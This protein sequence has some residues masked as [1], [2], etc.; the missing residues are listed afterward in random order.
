MKIGIAQTKPI[1]G[2]IEKNVQQHLKIIDRAIAHG[3][4]I[5][6]FPELSITGYEPELSKA[7]ATIPSDPRWSV[8]QEKADENQITI[9]L[10]L[11]MKKEDQSICI[12]MFIF[13]PAE[14]IQ[15]YSKEYLHTDEEPFFVKGKNEI[16]LLENMKQISFAICYEISVP[17]HALK[18]AQNGAKIY[19]ASVAKSV[20]GI[21]AAVGHLANIAKQ[22][23]MITLMSNCIGYCDN[24]ECGGKSA[25]WNEEGKL[26]G[27]LDD[28]TEG[29]L[30]LDIESRE[31]IKENFDSTKH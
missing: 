17:Q 4:D 3:A 14:A 31:L 12:S 7:L 30:I 23:S 13:Q 20:E 8:F 21:E 1:K 18:A 26:I 6:L 22:Y 15:I 2:D 25:I 19:M 24:F 5:I 28:K 27:Q 11:P 16:V 29:I 9:C 10:G